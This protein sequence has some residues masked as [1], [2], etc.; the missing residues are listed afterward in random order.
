MRV[1]GAIVLAVIAGGCTSVKM[2]QRD[3]CWIRRTENVLG[4]VHEEIGPCTR[5]QPKWVEDRFTRLVQECVAQADYR[6]QVSAIESWSRARPYPAQHPQDDV[7]RTCMQESRVQLA[8]E[9]EGLKS[10]IAELVADRDTLRTGAEQDRVRFQQTLDR[11]LGRLQDSHDRLAGY[12]GEAAQKPAGTATATASATS[13]GKAANESGATLSSG[14]NS[15]SGASGLQP[16]PPTTTA[17]QPAAARPTLAEA[18]RPAH[19]RS[20]RVNRPAP[21]RRATGPGCDAPAAEPAHTAVPADP[22]GP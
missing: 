4:R 18:Q 11:S 5:A 14:S 13:D 15:D 17:V 22:D 9:N 8:G 2:V 19:L 20:A 21:L 3:G 12:L 10:K 1:L 16:A 7:L 6:W